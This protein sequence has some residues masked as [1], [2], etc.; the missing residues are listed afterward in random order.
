[1]HNFEPDT[2]HV[3][4]PDLLE[5]IKYSIQQRQ[6][7][8]IQSHLALDEC[9]TGDV[10]LIGRFL[11]LNGHVAQYVVENFD[12]DV[13]NA[14]PAFPQCEYIFTADLPVREQGVARIEYAGRAVI[15]D[16]ELQRNNLPESLLLRVGQPGRIRRLRRHERRPSSGDLFLMPGL[17]LMDQEPINRRRLLALLGH[18]YRQKNRHKPKLVDISAG[19]VC[20]ESHDPRCNRF[21]GCEESY[22]FFFFSENNGLL[23]SPNVFMG[24]KV[25]IYR[26]E[27][28]NPAG[29]RIRFLKELV[30]TGPN[31]ELKWKDVEADGSQTI[32]KMLEDRAEKPA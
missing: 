4:R 15:L 7:A 16:Q 2:Y 9:N 29:L 5:V 19:G 23:N 1:M 8:L 25:G 28:G 32:R 10:T 17:M 6:K 30:W 3:W 13:S 11:G 31:E 27:D 18:Y 24:K 14:F 22:L 21:L 20:L 26:G 12:L